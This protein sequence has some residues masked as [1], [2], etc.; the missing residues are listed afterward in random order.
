MAVPIN[1]TESTAASKHF[2]DKVL[3][4]SASQLKAYWSKLIF[5]GKGAPPKSVES[6]Q[7]MLS[8]VASNP[9]IIGYVDAKELDSSVKVIAKF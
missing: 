3:K 5:T 6:A 9:N 1:L 7:E 8:L 2:N 4:K